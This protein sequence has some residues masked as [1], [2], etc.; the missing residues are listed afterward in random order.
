MPALP[1]P[2]GYH[3]CG[4]TN[5]NQTF[6]LVVYGGYY[7]NAQAVNVVPSDILIFNMDVAGSTWK[8]LSGK[9]YGGKFI[10]GGIIKR[11]TSNEC[12]MMFIDT[13]FKRVH[14]CT[15]NFNWSSTNI[16]PK[17]ISFGYETNFVPVG[18]NNF[19]SCF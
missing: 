1:T 3:G 13:G 15:G 6:H 8:V 18:V 4:T 2:R 19:R 10:S 14:T 12:N 5:I 17:P 9:Y 16:Q 11:L 7:N